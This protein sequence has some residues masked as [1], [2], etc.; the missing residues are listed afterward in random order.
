MQPVRVP[1]ELQ[2]LRTLRV[3]P[4][5]AEA[6][7]QGLRAKQY[8]VPVTHN[9]FST[10]RTR[11]QARTDKDSVESYRDPARPHVR[12]AVRIGRDA[13]GWTVHHYAYIVDQHGV[14]TGEDVYV[15]IEAR[16]R[17]GLPV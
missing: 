13:I 4:A 9:G 7:T 12:W 5:A 8:A 17:A 14:P 15:A 6:W 2:Q 3:A 10:R 11:A 1:T 16:K